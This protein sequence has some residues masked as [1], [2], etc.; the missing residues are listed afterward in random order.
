VK[1]NSSV[2]Q[3]SARA[4]ADMTILTSDI[5][6]LINRM[7]LSQCHAFHRLVVGNLPQ[8]CSSWSGAN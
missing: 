4:S 6:G 5:I 2:K 3:A 8:A 7:V 1:L